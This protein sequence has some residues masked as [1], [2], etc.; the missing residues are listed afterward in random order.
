MLAGK[1]PGQELLTHTFP[2]A[3]YQDAFDDATDKARTDCV[4]AAFDFTAA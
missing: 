2:L 3:N 4:K 1:L